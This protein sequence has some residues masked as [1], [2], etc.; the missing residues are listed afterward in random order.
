M[1]DDPSMVMAHISVVGQDGDPEI[2]P[3]SVVSDAPGCQVTPPSAVRSI[4][5]APL[6]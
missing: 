3:P 4:A 6:A 1:R 5:A 2:G